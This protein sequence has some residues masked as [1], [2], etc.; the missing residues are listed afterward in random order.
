MDI[1][2]KA[3]Q[4]NPNNKTAH[5]DLALEFFTQGSYNKALEHFRTLENIDSHNPYVFFNIG[6]I[7]FKF[8][9]WDNALHY[10][11]KF[12]ELN[13]ESTESYRYLG[14]IYVTKGEFKKGYKFYDKAYEKHDAETPKLWC[15][16]NLFGKTIYIWNN[17]G[18]GDVFCFT[19]YARKMKEQGAKEIILAVRKGLIPIMSSCP[20][21]DKVI[22]RFTQVPPCDFV[23]DVNRL[24]RMSYKAGFKI[25]CGYKNPYLFANQELVNKYKKEFSEDKNFKIGLCWDAFSYKNK[26]TGKRMENERSIPLHHFYFL[27]KLKGVSLYSL[28]RINGIEQLDYMPK[29]FKIHVF[30]KNFDKTMGSFSDTAAVMKNLDLVITADT[31]VANLAGALGVRVWV[32]L[33]FAADWRWQ[34]NSSY[35]GWYPNMKLFR[36]FDPSRFGTGFA[37]DRATNW[38]YPINQIEN[39]LCGI[40]K[41]K[42]RK[43]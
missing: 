24:T 21:V 2:K 4:V 32:L 14:R 7:F 29:N 10:F 19:Q 39:E 35:T 8:G 18:I 33:P 43:S 6:Y 1:Y 41:E 22:P 3:L 16:Q 23:I 31:S 37:Q 30:D 5:W 38:K 28:Q 17:V 40:L 27:S 13:P 34:L 12:L 20:Y 25:P 15:G 36:P 42:R 9:Q 11:N 26:L